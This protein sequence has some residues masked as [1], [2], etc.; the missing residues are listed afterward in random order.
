MGSSGGDLSLSASSA[1][2]RFLPFFPLYYSACPPLPREAVAITRFAR[3]VLVALSSRPILVESLV[4]FYTHVLELYF[5][6]L[7]ASVSV[8]W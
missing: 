3:T 5:D 2:S 6:Q 7:K 4:L 1:F 8:Q